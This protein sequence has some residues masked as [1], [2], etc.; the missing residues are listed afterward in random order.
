MVKH[1]DFF[2]NFS[3]D[4]QFPFFLV[5]WTIRIVINS[6]FKLW[7]ISLQYSG[8]NV[9]FPECVFELMTRGGEGGLEKG[10]VVTSLFI[11]L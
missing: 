7:M 2:S 3:I 6:I 1:I 4:F 9:Y 10:V 8:N 11:F 5:L